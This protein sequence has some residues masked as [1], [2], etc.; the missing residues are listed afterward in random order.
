M[1]ALFSLIIGNSGWLRRLGSAH[2]CFLHFRSPSNVIFYF[3]VWLNQK[4]GL[5]QTEWTCKWCI[6]FW[7]RRT[8]LSGSPFPDL[9]RNDFASLVIKDRAKDGR[10]L[11]PESL[12]GNCLMHIGQIV[13]YNYY[14]QYLGKQ[15]KCLSTPV[16]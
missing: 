9:L 6:H 12:C 7:L 2:I 11:G 15:I 8:F 5:Y 16:F 14:L 10:S 3:T 1:L 13:L 4:T